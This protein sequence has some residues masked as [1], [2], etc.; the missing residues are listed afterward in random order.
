[1][2]C[3]LDGLML[4]GVFTFSPDL[5]I[6]DVNDILAFELRKMSFRHEDFLFSRSKNNNTYALD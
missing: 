2:I 3:P 6:V 1:V 5:W 4:C